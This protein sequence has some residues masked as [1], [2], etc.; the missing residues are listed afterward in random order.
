DVL[1]ILDKT[2]VILDIKT[3]Q[4]L[5]EIFAILEDFANMQFTI[6][7]DLKHIIRECKTMRPDIPAFA[8]RH[9]SPFGLMKT[10]EKYGADGL[11]LNFYWLNPVTYRAIKRKGLQVQVY[12]VNNVL[13]AQL[14]KKLYPG[15]WICTNH[16]DKFLFALNDQ[17]KKK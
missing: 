4:H 12:T 3:D 16:P 6:V 14:L 5:S 8:Q 11:N 1:S 9:Y 15:I 7:T 10:I 2:P 17:A 13:V